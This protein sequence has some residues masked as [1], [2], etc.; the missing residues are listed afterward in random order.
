MYSPGCTEYYWAIPNILVTP[1]TFALIYFMMMIITIGFHRKSKIS[2]H[3]MVEETRSNL[4]VQSNESNLCDQGWLIR[5]LDYA[6][7]R[8]LDVAFKM[9]WTC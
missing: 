4:L 3:M 8:N 1:L 2:I 6:H 5:I 7:P 9:M